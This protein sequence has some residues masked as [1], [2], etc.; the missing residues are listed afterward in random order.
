MF[1]DLMAKVNNVQH[2]MGN[3]SRAI[4]SIKIKHKF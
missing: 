2:Q 4:K 3:F 1:K